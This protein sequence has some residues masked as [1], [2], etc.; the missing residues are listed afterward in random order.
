[1]IVS[2][3]PFRGAAA[4]TAFLLLLGSGCAQH[5]TWTQAGTLARAS[6][7]KLFVAAADNDGVAVV[8][9]S[10]SSGS[11]AFIPTGSRPEHIVIR[12]NNVFVSNR[13]SRSVTQIDA[14]TRKVVRQIA[15]GAEPMGMDFTSN[16]LLLVTNAMSGTL[17]AI[18]V[19]DGSTAWTVSLQEQVRAVAV[20]GN[21]EAWVPSYKNG[22]MH[23]IDTARGTE[24]GKPF[25]ISATNYPGYQV[26]GVECIVAD[27]FRGGVLIPHT[28]SAGGALVDLTLPGPTVTIQGY[29]SET[30]QLPGATGAPPTVPTV[31]A[32]ATSHAVTSTSLATLGAGV[33]GPKVAV[34]GP[35]GNYV[36]ILGYLASSLGITSPGGGA[37]TVILVGNGPNGIAITPDDKNAFVY[38]SFDHSI[39]VVGQDTG[40]NITVLR[41]INA[42]T[43]QTLAPNLQNGRLL[44]NSAADPRLS[45]QGVG[46]IACA[47]CHPDGRE[48]GHTWSFV[49]GARNT[50]ALVG[51]HLE[52]TAPYHWDGELVDPP[53]F[54]AVVTVRMGGSGL[55]DSDYFDIFAWLESEPAPDNPNLAADGTLTADQT[56]GKALFASAGCTSCHTGAAFTDNKFYDVATSFTTVPLADSQSG[57]VNKSAIQSALPNTPSLLGL[58][59]S[60]PYLHDGSKQT[61][62]QRIQQNPGDKHGVTSGLS[63]QQVNQLVA[64][65][66][67]L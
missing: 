20:L 67:T 25:D 51:R 65:L 45:S 43:P 38:N 60:A 10:A 48:D 28:Q 19:S 7:G 26:R 49:E 31:T 24:T 58:F 30:V 5:V 57:T 64:Y 50:P 11:L 61:L 59:A 39:S 56:A 35:A 16:G 44:F 27:P 29:Y 14:S 15:V 41:T 32:V 33:E 23:V 8:D 9:P 2:R 34:L 22:V 53:A 37:P 62:Q 47:S 17:Q 46:G 55:Q 6:D 13:Q 63:D 18:R 54:G 66:N 1:M 4:P 12:D 36:Y 3:N 42:V 52:L 21:G 40:G